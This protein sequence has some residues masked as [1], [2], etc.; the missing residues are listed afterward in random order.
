[1]VASECLDKFVT[2]RAAVFWWHHRGGGLTMPER[3]HHLSLSIKYGQGFYVGVRGNQ[4]DLCR[5]TSF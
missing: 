1:M 5:I 4:P 3:Q 2:S